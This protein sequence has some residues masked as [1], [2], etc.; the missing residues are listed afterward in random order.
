M[1]GLEAFGEEFA[2]KYTEKAEKAP[3]TRVVR[4]GLVGETRKEVVKLIVEKMTPEA[5]KLH[6]LKG[7]MLYHIALVKTM[8]DM[9]LKPLQYNNVWSVTAVMGSD[10][11]W[12]NVPED[13]KDGFLSNT[14]YVVVGYMKIK[15]PRK[16]GD[17]PF[18]TFRVDGVIS[19]DEIKEAREAKGKEE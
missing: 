16:E 9:E 18:T 5:I 15:P 8:E 14:H 12:L 3:V 6:Y 10:R 13:L 1:A 17:L 19:M 4:L 7:S 2:K 11:V